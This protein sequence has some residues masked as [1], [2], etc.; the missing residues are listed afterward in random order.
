MLDTSRTPRRTTL[1]Y[2]ASTQYLTVLLD[3]ADLAQSN[4]QYY[5]VQQILRTALKYYTALQ[6]LHKALPNIAPLQI[7]HCTHNS[8]HITPHTPHFPL[9]LIPRSKMHS[10]ST[11]HSPHFA[12]QTSHSKLDTSRFNARSTLQTAHPDTSHF[13]LVL[14]SLH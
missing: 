4:P 13:T 8:P 11:L 5:F 10:H 7:Q 1:Y 12:L 6:S 14:Q 9:L 2:K 3:T